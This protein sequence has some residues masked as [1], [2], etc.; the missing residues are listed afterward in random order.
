MSH[1]TVWSICVDSA[2][3]LWIGTDDGLNRFDPQQQTFAHY[4]E[5][6]GLPN[7]R[8]YGILE[9]DTPADGRG[10]YLWLST[11]QGL[12]RF[13]PI[14]GAVKTYGM[15]EL[16][17]I[18]FNRGAAYKSPTGEL[19]FGGMNGFNAF[20]PRQITENSHIPAVVLT[21]FQ[22]FNQPVSPG[23]SKDGRMILQHSIS[24]TQSLTLSYKD[25]VFA[26]EF[27]ALDY[28]IPS[29]NRYAYI[30]EGF[31]QEWNVVGTR[32]IATYTN[33]PPGRYVFRV[34]GSN[35]DG[36]WSENGTAVRI[37][38]TPPFWQTAWFRILSALLMAGSVFGVYR[39][40]VRTIQQQ[41]RA[42]EIQVQERTAELQQK[43][44][45]LHELNASKDKFFSIISHDLRS[46]FNALLGYTQL[47]AEHFQSYSTEEVLTQIEKI[48]TSA[49]RLYALLENLLT[50]SRVQRGAMEFE[51]ED[52][53][54][55]D[56]VEYNLDLFT[57]SAEQKQIAL[58]NTIQHACVVHADYN[59]LNTVF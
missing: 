32:R 5:A 18:M 35:N 56:M 37:L 53:D 2:G 8:I 24:E 19:F 41:K 59:M 50:W 6:D 23:I 27:A 46:P 30:M 10:G 33:L 17:N 42:L 55:Q 52:F 31:D 12:C 26:F 34:K 43:N 36:V 39:L 44:V 54:L 47:L 38:I 7:N 45:Q 28:T 13:D 29:E 16:Q 21:D 1:D 15:N 3:R 4:T 58:N 11:A 48:R 20:T 40:R 51:P 9:G 49:K 22:I 14:S 25:A 57:S